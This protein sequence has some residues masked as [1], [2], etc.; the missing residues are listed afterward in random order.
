VTMLRATHRVEKTRR[1]RTTIHTQ[2]HD[3][4]QREAGDGRKRDKTL[5]EEIPYMTHADKEE[6]AQIGGEENVVWRILLRGLL[7]LGS[8]FMRRLVS[9]IFIWAKTE[10]QMVSRDDLF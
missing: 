1:S 9:I 3:L 8:G 5:P 2:E 7:E 6:I 4:H 10:L